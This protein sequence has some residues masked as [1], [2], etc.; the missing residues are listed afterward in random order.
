PRGYDA[1]VGAGLG[2]T[3]EGKDGCGNVLPKGQ[4]PGAKLTYQSAGRVSQAPRIACD[5]GQRRRI[6]ASCAHAYAPEAKMFCRCAI[7]ILALRAI[8]RPAPPRW[9]NSGD[10][11]IQII[12]ER[13][14]EVEGGLPGLLSRDVEPADWF[15]LV[16]VANSHHSNSPI[17]GTSRSA[18]FI[19]HKSA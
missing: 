3:L 11:G 6:F 17:L 2:E 13:V 12:S 8:S 19:I 4:S 10:A 18:Y 15:A 14:G 16:L 1:E 7:G 9:N 5:S